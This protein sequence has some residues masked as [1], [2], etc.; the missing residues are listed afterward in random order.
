MRFPIK[1]KFVCGNAKCRRSWSS[2]QAL[3]LLTVQRSR[4][5]F[6]FSVTALE[7]SCQR[8]GRDVYVRMYA[9]EAGRVADWMQGEAPAAGRLHGMQLWPGRR[10][11]T[12]PALPACPAPLQMRT[13]EGSILSRCSGRPTCGGHMTSSAARPAGWGCTERGSFDDCLWRPP[14]ACGTEG[15]PYNPCAGMRSKDDDDSSKG[16]SG[17]SG[18]RGASSG[19]GGQ[20]SG[21]ITR[22]QRS[23]K[24]YTH[25]RQ[26]RVGK[27][28]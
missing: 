1:G 21:G 22:A 5:R 13:S 18:E 26:E 23:I 12:Q 2:A 27:L 11:A 20:G 10:A 25:K 15:G 14:E 3:L 19:K 28:G 24:L 7:Q 8:C 9:D 16:S 4:S 17:E 6:V